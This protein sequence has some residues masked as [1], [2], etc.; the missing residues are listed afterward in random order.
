MMLLE[1]RVDAR[2]VLTIVDA[3]LN[4]PLEEPRPPTQGEEPRPP[5]P[6]PN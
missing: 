6:S 4:L 2:R 3:I 5:Q 1:T